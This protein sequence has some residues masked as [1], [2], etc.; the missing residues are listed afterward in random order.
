MTVR[1]FLILPPVRMGFINHDIS[2][3]ISDKIPILDFF[4]SPR[5]IRVKRAHSQK[6]MD[7]RIAIPFVVDTPISTH[8]LIHKCFLDIVGCILNLFLSAPFFW[9]GKFK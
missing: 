4:L 2:V 9:E 7:M 8:S 1:V 3:F 5:M 6:Q